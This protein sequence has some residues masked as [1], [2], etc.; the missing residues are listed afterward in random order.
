MI[1]K[2][3]LLFLIISIT[4]FFAATVYADPSTSAISGRLAANYDS[5]SGTVT[6]MVAGYCEGQPVIIG[7]VT[8]TVSEKDILNLNA[9]DIGK[10]VCGDRF[11]IKKVTK[12]VK[13][14]KEMVADVVI[15]RQ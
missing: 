1:K 3:A 2:A 10:T 13:N 14:G 5:K 11:S 7:P 15:V 12:S 8:W 9:E 6:A 4:L